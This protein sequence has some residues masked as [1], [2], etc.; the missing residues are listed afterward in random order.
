MLAELT[1]FTG[2][3][4]VTTAL[5]YNVLSLEHSLPQLAWLR[6]TEEHVVYAENE[7]YAVTVYK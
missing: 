6:V 7:E 5:T 2:G 1:D 4:R 3:P